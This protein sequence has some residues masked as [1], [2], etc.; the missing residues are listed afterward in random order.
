MIFLDVLIIVLLFLLFGISHTILASNKLKQKLVDLVGEKIAFYRLFYNV[1]SLIILIVILGIAPKPD[2]I[3][4]DLKFP[5]DLIIFA[6]QVL[7]I[8]GFFWASKGIGIQEFLGINQIYR[9]FDNS[10]QVED[11]DERSTLKLDGAYKYSRH[12][13]YLFSILFLVLRPTMDLFY[14]VMLICF[15]LYFYIGSIFEEKKL[16]DKYGVEYQDYQKKVPRIFPIKFSG[17]N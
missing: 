5:F 6:L 17:S 15:V 10:Y 7:S 2:V 11:L 16:V 12:P 13:I 8:V 14:F 3:L 9:Y 1:A 4:Y